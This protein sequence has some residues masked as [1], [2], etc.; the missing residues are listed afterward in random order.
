MDFSPRLCY[1][2]RRGIFFLGVGG[3]GIFTDYLF[4]WATK[5]NPE[6]SRI[7]I[8]VFVKEEYVY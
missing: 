6:M 7:L 2:C 4:F 3:G 8:L 5:F 1:C